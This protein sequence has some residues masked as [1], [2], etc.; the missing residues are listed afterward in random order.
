MGEGYKAMM[1]AP[2]EAGNNGLIAGAGSM[3]AGGTGLA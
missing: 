1:N 2:K 3:V